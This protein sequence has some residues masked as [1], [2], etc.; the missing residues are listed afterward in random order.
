MPIRN[1]HF[2]RPLF[3]VL[4]ALL[5]AN[6]L[7]MGCSDNG[8]TSGIEARAKGTMSGQC[9]IEIVKQSTGVSWI[10]IENVTGPEIIIQRH[11]DWW[12]DLWF[13]VA[14]QNGKWSRLPRVNTFSDIDMPDHTDPD[15]VSLMRGD[16]ASWCLNENM[17]GRLTVGQRIRLHW[18]TTGLVPQVFAKSGTEFP[19]DPLV[20]ELVVQSDT[21]ELP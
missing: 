14:D 5:L 7:P 19:R 10:S 8:R 21:I 15:W 1:P 6:T 16:Q 4:A 12:G 17:V 20:V 3:G 18:K 9:N 13:E 11:S 2:Q